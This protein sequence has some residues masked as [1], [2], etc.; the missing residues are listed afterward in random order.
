MEDVRKL[1]EAEVPDFLNE[2]SDAFV[3]D[4]FNVIQY[5]TYLGA[6]V[7]PNPAALLQGL[8]YDDVPMNLEPPPFGP[9]QNGSRKRPYN[10]R[11][12]VDMQD[13][14]EYSANGYKQPRRGRGGRS[15]Y[16]AGFGRGAAAAG[17]PGV[18]GY[19][20]QPQQPQFGLPL[21]GSAPAFDPANMESFMKM[22]SFMPLP[23][24]GFPPQ[25][26]Q[27]FSGPPIRRQLCRDY[28]T[29]GYCARGNSCRFDHPT[30]SIFV[31]PTAPQTNEGEQDHPRHGGDY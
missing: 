21:S 1:C 5:R 16:T 22:Q 28:E 12:D 20:P 31:P 14:G 18:G 9:G 11:G 30:D 29:K 13:V 24:P 6:P 27:G 2:D 7:M 26:P 25:G 17:F 8:P 4:V 3:R 15:D 23:M 19:Q 10:E